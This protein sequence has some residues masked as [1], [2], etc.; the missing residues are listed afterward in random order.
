MR[1]GA[2]ELHAALLIG[3]RPV[4]AALGP[5]DPVVARLRVPIDRIA[6]WPAGARDLTV[7]ADARPDLVLHVERVDGTDPAA[8]R[9]AAPEASMVPVDPSTPV[10]EQLRL[11]GRLVGRAAQ[12]EQAVA[13][14]AYR[15]G[16]VAE[17]VAA[18]PLARAAV[19]LAVP[20]PDGAP[21][22]LGPLAPGGAA[23]RAAGAGRVLDDERDLPDADVVLRV[24]AGPATTPVAVGTDP[25]WGVTG[26]T[27]AVRREEFLMDSALVRLARLI[28]IERV[29]HLL[30]GPR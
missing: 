25:R 7:L 30:S 3:V 18:S 16:L 1:I 15:A 2:E 11:V 6:R 28:E 20:S 29:A 9:A 26:H 24:S 19:A 14:H 17:V 23:L 5:G 4:A 21:R 27:V 10:D 22:L 12:A 13:G 8:L